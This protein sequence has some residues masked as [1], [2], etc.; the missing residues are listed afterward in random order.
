M[1]A[2]NSPFSLAGMTHP[3]T[4]QGLSSFLL[5]SYGLFRVRYYLQPKAQPACLQ[6]TEMT[7]GQIPLV[8]HYK[9]RQS[10]GLLHCLQLVCHIY[11]RL[12]PFFNAPSN[13]SSTNRFLTRSIV[14]SLSSGLCIFPYWFAVR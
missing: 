2:T 8:A 11:A 13:P 12:D 6:V 1:A 3:T 5:M 14:A 10:D 7:N 9:S 4:F